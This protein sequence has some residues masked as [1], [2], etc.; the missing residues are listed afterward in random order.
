[1]LDRFGT[2]VPGLRDLTFVVG[3]A[4]NPTDLELVAH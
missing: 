2:W 1:M 4:M 3:H